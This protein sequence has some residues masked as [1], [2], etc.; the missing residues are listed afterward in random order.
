MY[1]CIGS[2]YTV[3]EIDCQGESSSIGN[4]LRVTLGEV[5]SGEPKATLKQLMERLIL[6]SS[7]TID[8]VDD[9]QSKTIDTVELSGTLYCKRSKTIRDNFKM[10]TS[11]KQLL[12]LGKRIGIVKD[13][14]KKILEWNIKTNPYFFKLK[15]GRE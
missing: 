3:I 8:L 10:N 9:F 7:A 12:D 11:E 6:L 15:L 2:V 14:T 5:K 13:S 4:A 1:V